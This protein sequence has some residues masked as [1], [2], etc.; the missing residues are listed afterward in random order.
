M[1]EEVLVILKANLDGPVRLVFADGEIIDARRLSVLEEED[2][3]AF[4][5]I[6]SS[7]PYKY[8]KTDEPLGLVAKLSELLDC[9]PL[10]AQ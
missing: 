1:T 5:L 2:L 8:E 4:E 9:Q 7:R 6:K 10:R 3:I